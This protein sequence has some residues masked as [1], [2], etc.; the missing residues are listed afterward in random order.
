MIRP[1][2][3]HC[4]VCTAADCE[5]LHTQRFVLPSGHPLRD[6]Y[7]VVACVGCG[8]V[9]A[10]TAATQ[11]D[12]DRYYADLSKYTDDTTA[13]GSGVN[14]HDARRLADDV[15]WFAE[16]FPDR[17]ARLVDVGCANGGL[18]AALRTVGFRNLCGVDPS[19]AC[20][21]NVRRLGIEA[22]AGWLEAIPAAAGPADGVLL[23]QVLEHVRELPPALAAVRRVLMPAGRVYVGVPDAARY[24]DFVNAPF[25]DFNTEHINHFSQT[26]LANLA[27]AAGFVPIARGERL[28]DLAPDKPF[29]VIFQLWEVADPPRPPA[30][31]RRDPGLQRA[32]GLYIDKSRRLLA[33][34][35]AALRRALPAG[36][37]VVWGVGQLTMELLAETALGQAEVAAF[38]DNNPI[39]HGQTIRGV[40]VLP[41]AEARRF[42]HPIVVGSMLHDRAIAHQ[43]AEELRLPNRLILPS[44]LLPSEVRE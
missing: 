35:D 6:G 7:D 27:A 15:A 13:T 41:P 10:D 43:V 1:S 8:F 38:L 24:A 18:L 44:E 2:I 19:P 39:N 32:V 42:P 3:R 17:S 37:V 4:P 12:Y 22:H 28:M 30:R 20:V 11:A 21:A 5:V 36:P 31:F 29:P 40:R 34:L 26:T 14:L 23:T 9:F 25:Q 16:R 33:A